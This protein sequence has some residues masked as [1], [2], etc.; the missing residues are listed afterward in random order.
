MGIGMGISS[1]AFSVSFSCTDVDFSDGVVEVGMGGQC[2]SHERADQ[3]FYSA[4]D[5]IQLLN[6]QCAVSH[7]QV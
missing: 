4:Y 6:L 3:I 5:T 7:V 1:A 2:M